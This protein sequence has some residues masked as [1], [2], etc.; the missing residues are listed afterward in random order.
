MQNR[1]AIGYFAHIPADAFPLYDGHKGKKFCC[2]EHSGVMIRK[3]VWLVSPLP[4]RK[5][6]R[7]EFGPSKS[8]PIARTLCVSSI[9]ADGA[10]NDKGKEEEP[11]HAAQPPTG[12][13]LAIKY[14]PSATTRGV[15]RRHRS[16]VV[17]VLHKGVFEGAGSVGNG[18]LVQKLCFECETENVPTFW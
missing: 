4:S 10:S 11:L 8:V 13:V 3:L 1:S 7:S 9:L 15:P 14:I 5:R 2:K 12:V 16:P 6:G 18:G 17:F